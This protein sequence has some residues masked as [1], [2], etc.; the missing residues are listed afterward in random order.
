[1][2]CEILSWTYVIRYTH[3]VIY[4]HAIGIKE[5]KLKD[6]GFESVIGRIP[7]AAATLTG[8]NCT[9]ID[10]LWVDSVANGVVDVP[11]KRRELRIFGP[12]V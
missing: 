5:N 12:L 8:F 10:S 3:G 11:Q 9:L 2:D 6:Y 4:S 7:S 1:M